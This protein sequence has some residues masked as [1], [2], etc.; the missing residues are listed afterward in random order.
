MVL[1]LLWRGLKAP[2]YLHRWAERFG[3]FEAPGFSSRPIWVHAV[4]VGESQAA[5]PLIEALLERYP[6]I[7][8]IVTTTTPTG[9]ARVKSLFGDRVWHVYAPYDLPLS[10]AG[11]LGRVQPCLAVIMETEIWPNLFAGCRSRKIPVVLANARLSQRSA[12][13]YR[14]L[15]T[16]TRSTL[17]DITVIAAQDEAARQRFIG[18]G[19]LRDRVEITGSIKF[20]LKLPASLREQGEVLRRQWG[21]GRP[22]WIAASTHEGEDE[23]VLEAFALVRNEVADCLLVLVPR[24]PE[25]FK[26]V[27]NLARKHHF[28]VVLRSEGQFCADVQSCD[29]YL[30]DTMGEL[31][32]FYAASDLAFVGGSLI[33]VGGHNM[34]EPAALGIPVL[35][36][37]HVFNFEEISAMLLVHEGA[38]T[39]DNRH[40][41]AAH[42]ISL[43]SDANQRHSMGENGKQWVEANKG[44]LERLLNR[45]DSLL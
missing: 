41:L 32:L 9:S 37:P 3:V 8:V 34:L 11:F 12:D 43:L 33:P 7:P 40:E 25:R 21:V 27:A 39:V 45:L 14:K 16:L 13:G 31:P 5:A 22:V 24:H 18:L 28:K 6:D 38:R 44:A 15:A 20:D 19:A 1:R 36:G 23:Q 10:V 42:V 4:S 26:T 29:V 17:A 35:L 2:A 30:G